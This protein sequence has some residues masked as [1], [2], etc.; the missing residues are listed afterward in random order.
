MIGA[1]KGARDCF[2]PKIFFDQNS[3]RLACHAMT[4]IVSHS[5]RYDKRSDASGYLCLRKGEH[6]KV[7]SLWPC[8]T[9]HTSQRCGDLRE[10]STLP[11]LQSH[12]ISRRGVQLLTFARRGVQLLT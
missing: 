4:G 3:S 6:G 12:I 1:Q 11:G 2:A 9:P 5:F 8:L 7:Y 10:V